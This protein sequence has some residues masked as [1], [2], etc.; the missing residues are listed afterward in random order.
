[1]TLKVKSRGQDGWRQLIYTSAGVARWRL[2]TCWGPVEP[3]G[4]IEA[5]YDDTNLHMLLWWHGYSRDLEYL[6]ISQEMLCGDP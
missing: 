2:P 5:H 6:Q 1:M 4:R 3:S